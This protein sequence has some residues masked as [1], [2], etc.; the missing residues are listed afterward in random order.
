MSMKPRL[1]MWLWII[2]GAIVVPFVVGFVLGIFGVG[3][4]PGM[5]TT[6]LIFGALI[7]WMIGRRR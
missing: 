1:E 4:P 2:G 3:Q 6:L 7:G 5:P